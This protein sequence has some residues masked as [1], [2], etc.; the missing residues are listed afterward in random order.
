[1]KISVFVIFA[2]I[3]FNELITDLFQWFNVAIQYRQK[4]LKSLSVFCQ[5]E[6]FIYK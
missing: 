1:M 6:Q 5:H 3:I 4:L 2:N